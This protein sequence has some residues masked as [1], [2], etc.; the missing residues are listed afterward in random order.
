MYED[1]NSSNLR[2][3]D[4]SD[5]SIKT[6][7]NNKARF[8][9]YSEDCTQAMKLFEAKV[10]SIDNIYL[11]HLSLS[12]LKSIKLE[13][14]DRFNLKGLDIFMTKFTQLKILNLYCTDDIDTINVS[15]QISK[16]I[17][18]LK[19]E[20]K[21]HL[22]YDFGLK[23]LGNLRQFKS[24]KYINFDSFCFDIKSEN[25]ITNMDK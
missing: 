6:N 21:D 23:Y 13:L 1:Y 14:Y 11:I 18:N 3:K 5:S 20:L 12:K 8:I 15:K 19:S 17:S 25:N 24:I 4:Y 7:T 22:K 10:D 2:K 16:F 9:I